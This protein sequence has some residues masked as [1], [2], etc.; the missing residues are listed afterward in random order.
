[1]IP[2]LFEEYKIWHDAIHL[3]PNVI[4]V[5]DGKLYP[6]IRQVDMQVVLSMFIR[7]LMKNP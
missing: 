2:E 6:K 3:C 7:L 4:A 1:M 5:S